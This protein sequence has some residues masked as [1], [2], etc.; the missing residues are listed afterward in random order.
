[1]I[2]ALSGEPDIGIPPVV[3]GYARSDV[4]RVVLGTHGKRLTLRVRDGFFEYTALGE[5]RLP[6]IER[7]TIELRNG[8]TRAIRIGR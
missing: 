8:S 3:F 5:R 6:P 2:E 1:M 4:R 7:I